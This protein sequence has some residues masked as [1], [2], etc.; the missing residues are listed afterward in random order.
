M[1]IT[2]AKIAKKIILKAIIN[3]I[4]SKKELELLKRNFVKKLKMP[5]LTNSELFKT[6]QKI[7][8]EKRLRPLPLLE[9]ILKKKPIRSLSGIVNVS[10]LTKPYFCP[11]KCIF[12]PLEK[13]IPKSYL[14]GEPAAERAKN[15]KYNPF[16]QVQKRIKVLRAGGHSTDKVELRILG[17]TFSVYPK[18]Y[19]YWFL[20]ECFRAANEKTWAVKL[21]RRQNLYSLKNALFIEQKRNEKAQN[22]IV[23]ISI[24]TRPD[25]IKEEEIK[26]LR[27]LGV[28]MVE[29]GIQN[30]FDEILKKNKTG[31][32][33]E[34]IIIATKL[35][36]DAGFKVLY[37]LMPNLLGAT[38][39]MDLENFKTVF[40]NENFKPDWIKIYPLVVVKNSKM[41]DILQKGN[42]KPYS[43]KELIQLLIK[44]KSILPK[45][46]RIARIMRDIPSQKI[47]AGCKISNLREVIKKEMTNQKLNCQC[48]RCREVKENYDPKEKIFLFKEDYEASGGKEFF[49]SFENKKRT[50]LLSYLRLRIPSFYFKREK[51]FL[52]VLN[53]AALVREMKTLGE[54]EKIGK[55]GISPQHR[56]LGKNLLKE[57]EKISKKIFGLNKIAVIAGIGVREYFRK[58]GYNLEHTYMV[59]RF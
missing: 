6:Y 34:K 35:L 48:I 53:G 45:W 50:K 23:G 16:L 51:H 20:K 2:R 31:L 27:D 54:L 21:S 15:L 14:S 26:K 47:V 12:C 24:E 55:K 8:K 59:K 52:P 25:F 41:F 43:E 49:L 46:V 11:G 28:T 33:T 17:G 13:N 40:S 57:A 9:R 29:M 19:Q 39:E 3:K 58:Y 7:L 32:N 10:V 4:K 22:R 56:G 44:I 30:V 1:Q 36:K 18:N 38:P 42:Y 37:H 5:L